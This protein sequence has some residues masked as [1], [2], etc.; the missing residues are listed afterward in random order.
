MRLAL[1]ASLF[2]FEHAC[3]TVHVCVCEREREKNSGSLICG[4][5]GIIKPCLGNGD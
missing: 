2:A 4:D 3:L 5:S 1:C